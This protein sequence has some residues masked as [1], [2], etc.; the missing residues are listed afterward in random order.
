MREAGASLQYGV[1]RSYRALASCPYRVCGAA[2]LLTLDGAGRSTLEVC[3]CVF[4]CVT[5]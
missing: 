3:V 5:A 4:L 2:Q 1:S